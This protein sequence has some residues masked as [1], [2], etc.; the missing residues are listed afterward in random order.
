MISLKKNILAESLA[1]FFNLFIPSVV[2]AFILAL[3]MYFYK[4]ELYILM[5]TLPLVASVFYI[6]IV[7]ILNA[8]LPKLKPGSYDL[9]TDPMVIIWYL[10]M[11]LNRSLKSVGL[12]SIIRSSSVLKY[13]HLR[14]LGAK[15]AY[16]ANFSAELELVDPSLITI[17]EG[18]IVGGRCYMG[19]HVVFDGKLILGT[20]HLKKNSFISLGNVIGQGT[21]VGEGAVVGAG[22]YLYRDEIPNNYK[23]PNFVWSKGS[24]KQQENSLKKEEDNLLNPE[25]SLFN[26]SYGLLNEESFQLQ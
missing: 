12:L 20:I 23:L 19:C 9:K 11:S 22:N 21:I 5:L 3:G 4:N 17:D 7:F 16:S 14:A 24:P 1:L 2:W 25:F 8:V 13:L 18:V 15:I 6:F 10:H 26:R